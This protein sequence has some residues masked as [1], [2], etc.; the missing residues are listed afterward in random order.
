VVDTSVIGKPLDPSTL[1]IERGPITNF[2]KAVKSDS[3]VYRNPEAAQAAGFDNVPTPPTYGFGMANWAAF[4]ELQPKGSGGTNPVMQ[5][6]GGLMKSGGLILH[7]EQEFFYHKPIV[8]GDTLQATGRISDH[9]AKTS[10]SG[11]TMTFIS[12]ETEYRNQN[13]ELV[14]TAV[15]TLVHKA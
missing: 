13:G 12:S 9:Y 7:G 1:V 8:A 5:V 2:A 14:L 11:S 6:I 15:M 3:A 4:E 10:S